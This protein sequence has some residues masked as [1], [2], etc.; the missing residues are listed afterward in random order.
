MNDRIDDV[1]ERSVR[2]V[3]VTERDT[4]SPGYCMFFRSTVMIIDEQEK[5]AN[6]VTVSTH[7]SDG[8]SNNLSKDQRSAR[9]Q[10]STTLRLFFSATS[11]P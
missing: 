11:A 8:T 2:R 1:T 10:R 6:D 7:L 5:H 9:D 4:A 3:L